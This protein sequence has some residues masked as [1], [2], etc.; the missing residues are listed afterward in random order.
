MYWKGKQEKVFKGM[1]V[2]QSGMLFI[3]YYST[4]SFSQNME[5][6]KVKI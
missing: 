1:R 6:I 4:L 3:F 2:G 5:R